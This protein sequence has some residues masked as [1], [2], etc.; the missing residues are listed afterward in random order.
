MKL[1]KFPQ[2]KKALSAWLAVIISTLFS[3][4]WAYWGIIENFHEGWY[5]ENFVE[6]LLMM[7]FQYLLITIIF[8][9]LSIIGIYFPRIGGTVLFLIGIFLAYFFRSNLAVVFPIICA[10]I[11]LLAVFYFFG[12]ITRKKIAAAVVLITPLLIIILFGIPNFWKVSQRYDDNDFSARIIEGNNVKLFW[13]PRGPGFPERGKGWDNAVSSCK[14]LTPD[15]NFF[16]E[17]EQNIWRLPTIEEIVRTQV[18][19]GKNAGGTWD[20]SRQKAT[21]SQQPDKES[22][23]WDMHSMIV[24][25]WTSEEKDDKS[26]YM[27]VY[28][29]GVYVRQKQNGDYLGFRC[30]KEL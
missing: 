19:H 29:G 10:P 24:Y 16:S 9:V 1:A 8:T 28:N 18:F 23:L 20:S 14:H 13:A 12:R 26:A 3:S 6:N 11:L 30:V 5:S 22:P 15:G 2:D 25:Y 27:V 7:F 21:Y 17:A 4:L